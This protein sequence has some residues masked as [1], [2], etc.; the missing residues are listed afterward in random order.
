MQLSQ[1]H[2][3]PN[4]LI[5]SNHQL[6]LELSLTILPLASTPPCSTP[7]Y[8]HWPPQANPPGHCKPSKELPPHP[9]ARNSCPVVHSTHSPSKV[10]SHRG[11]RRASLLPARASSTLLFSSP[12]RLSPAGLTR[13]RYTSS[14]AEW[15]FHYP[16]ARARGASLIKRVVGACR[17][18]IRP[19]H[20]VHA[21]VY[22]P[23]SHG[24]MRACPEVPLDA[25][26]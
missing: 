20:R 21:V 1:A 23:C 25:P 9:E 26:T 5:T 8:R 4:P 2:N 11:P 15:I 10:K 13:Q 6:S 22:H 14:P 18:A 19:T 16:G 3:L 12:L 17:A 24:Q 7:P